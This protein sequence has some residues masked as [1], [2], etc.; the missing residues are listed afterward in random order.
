MVLFGG[1][2]AE[3]GAEAE[4][5]AKEDYIGDHAC[6]MK[7]IRQMGDAA[8]KVE[9]K[10]R[11]GDDQGRVLSLPKLC[12]EAE[13]HHGRGTLDHPAHLCGD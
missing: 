3:V 1:R 2:T 8:Y 5:N 10:Q 9:K 12:A 4:E 11:L 7:N 13:Q 6:G